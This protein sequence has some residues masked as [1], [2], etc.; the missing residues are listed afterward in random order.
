MEI[1][2]RE[3]IQPSVTTAP[4]LGETLFAGFPHIREIWPLDNIFP[5]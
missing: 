2:D 4:V 3:L 1:I 5:A